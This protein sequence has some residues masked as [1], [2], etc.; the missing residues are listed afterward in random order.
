MFQTAGI[1][2][3]QIHRYDTSGTIPNKK[4]LMQ[5][6]GKIN[7]RSVAAAAG[8]SPA[9]VS[10][11]LNGNSAVNPALADKVLTAVQQLGYRPSAPQSSRTGQIVFIVPALSMT[12]YSTVADGM[13]DTA[14]R[15]NLSVSIMT[16]HA[17]PQRE[18]ECLRDACSSST[19]GIIYSPATERNPY[20]LFPMLRS[21]PLVITGP[22]HL[23]SGVPHICQDNFFAGYTATKYLL[24]LGHRRIAFI[25]NFWMNH[26]HSYDEFLREY[27]SPARDHF[28]AYDR[29][30]G[31]CK[32][33]EEE[34]MEPDPSLIVFGGFSYES[35]YESAR[36]LLAS[37][38]SFDAVL[39]PNDR[40]G[41][42]VLKILRQQ[43]LHVPEQVSIVCLNGGVLSDTMSPTLTVVEMNNYAMG[44]EAIQQMNRLLQ[45]ENASDVKIDAKLIIKNSTQAR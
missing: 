11:V 25:V 40:C 26:I 23:V 43:G 12:Y 6:V 31:F 19:T 1:F 42:G 33:L 16:S 5:P 29:Y 10:R 13:I 22:R 17:D 41:A 27:H 32:A 2:K 38:V 21:I 30:A 28:S 3:P 24:R 15:Y 8:V 37:S 36:Q 20:E 39:A 14:A 9:T 44:V 18:A 4:G 34:N 7:I 35:G 45:G